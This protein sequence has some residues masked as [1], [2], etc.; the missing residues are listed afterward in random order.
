M[1]TQSQRRRGLDASEIPQNLIIQLSRG[2][3][4]K[5]A[6]NALMRTTAPMRAHTEPAGT[7]WFQKMDRNQ[8]GDVS[9]AEFLGD[10]AAFQRLDLNGDGLIDA[11]EAMAASR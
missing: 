10:R 4:R 9:P 7:A 3:A 5:A 2:A 11:A 1:Q 6:A 8:D